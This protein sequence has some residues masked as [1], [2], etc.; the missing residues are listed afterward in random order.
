M[1]GRTAKPRILVVDDNADAAN[2]LGRLLS[3]M[4]YET[5]VAHD[6]HV[7]VAEVEHFQPQAVLLDLDM[8][9]MDGFEVAERIKARANGQ[10]VTLV[11][12]TG[13]GQDRDRQRTDAAGFAAHLVKPVN[14][15]QLERILRGV[16]AAE[17]NSTAASA[18]Q[19]SRG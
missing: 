1:A 7:A 15:D 8:P 16:T 5:R 18:P 4:G 14:I 11:A 10:P 13:W 6:G 9:V 3:L 12:V 17:S 2:S 19:R